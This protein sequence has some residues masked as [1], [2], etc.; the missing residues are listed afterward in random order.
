MPWER[1][2]TEQLG[3][4]LRVK[5]ELEELPGV[6]F[7]EPV[8]RRTHPLKVFVEVHL[9]P[10]SQRTLS[11]L[12]ATVAGLP[13]VAVVE[14]PKTGEVLEVVDLSSNGDGNAGD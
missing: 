7:V 2:T 12:P 4:F 8:F 9:D 11:M 13:V 5:P 10:G 1:L 6:Q 3:E 14:N